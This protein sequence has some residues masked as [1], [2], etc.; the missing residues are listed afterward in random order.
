M[1]KLYN[2]PLSARL[3]PEMKIFELIDSHPSLLSIFSRL[4]IKLPFGDISIREMC[5]RD[6]CPHELFM[7]LCYMHIDFGYRPDKELLTK[8]MILPTVGYLRATHRYY[9]EYMLPHAGEHLDQILKH[10]DNLSATMLRRF[11]DDYIK[12]IEE[13]LEEEEQTIF[14]LIEAATSHP[15]SDMSRLKVPHSD[16][17]DR[18]NDIASLIIKCMPEQTPTVL[19]CAMLAHIYA[20]RD[21]LL[22]HGNVELFLLK[23]LVDKFLTTTT[24]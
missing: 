7:M 12:C 9:L 17:E 19:R 11:Y 5:Q 2:G 22:R 8:D 16:I 18:T 20:L 15:I 13:H 10:C 24:L 6:G 23:P 3:S 21:D 4:D 1:N 14:S